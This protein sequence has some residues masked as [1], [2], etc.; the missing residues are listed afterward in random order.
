MSA[1]CGNDSKSKLQIIK[2]PNAKTQNSYNFTNTIY[3]MTYQQKIRKLY[4]LDELKKYGFS[5][6]EIVELE[7][8][9]GL[10]LPKILREYYLLLGKNKE[11]NFSFNRLLKPTNQAGF[12]NDKHFVFY[13]ENQSAVFW[14]IKEQDLKLDNP[15]V[16]GNFDAVGL[17]QEWFIDSPTTEDFLLS[18]ALWNG[19]LGG[20]KFNANTEAKNDLTKAVVNKVEENWT[21]I[22]G[23]TNQ[24]LRFFTGDF[25]EIIAF[26]TDLNSKING[27]FIGSN[28]KKKYKHIIDTLKIEWDYRTD[29]DE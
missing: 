26:T 27:L 16:Y 13:E 6:K 17:T 25:S 15:C 24:Q 5:E 28:D 20:L 3:K 10:I 11:I 29:R 12:S 14:G 4:K 9:E 7:K 2:K 18:M 19:V 21:E 8:R 1:N 23:I 22:K